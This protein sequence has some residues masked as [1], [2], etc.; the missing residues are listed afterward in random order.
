[1][2]TPGLYYLP[3][4]PYAFRM[5]KMENQGMVCLMPQKSH[6]FLQTHRT[7]LIIAERWVK[8]SM[9]TYFRITQPVPVG[10]AIQNTWIRVLLRGVLSVTATGQLLI[11]WVSSSSMICENQRKIN[12]LKCSVLGVERANSGGSDLTWF[13]FWTHHFALAGLWS[14]GPRVVLGTMW[15]QRSGT[16]V[17]SGPRH[18][19]STWRNQ[20]LGDD[21]AC[22]SSITYASPVQRWRRRRRRRVFLEQTEPCWVPAL[23]LY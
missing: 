11:N 14:P 8:R 20:P 16:S 18:C 22:C 21:P 15:L 9:L 6:V 1:M 19:A 4:I 13:Y 10:G 3:V 12:T 17:L 2:K 5:E 23:E 7:S